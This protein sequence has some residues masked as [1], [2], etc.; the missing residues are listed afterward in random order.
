M[1][2]TQDQEEEETTEKKVNKANWVLEMK[3]NMKIIILTTQ[4]DN[5]IETKN[6]GLIIE[7]MKKIL[8]IM[9]TQEVKYLINS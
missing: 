5:Q 4:V 6:Q 7:M 9:I 8:K 2:L 3:M 1:K